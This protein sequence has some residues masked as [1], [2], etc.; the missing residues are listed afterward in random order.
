ELG[1]PAGVSYQVG[2]HLGCCPMNDRDQVERLAARLGAA[3]DG[4]FTVPA[5][6]NVR[7]VPKGVVLQVRNVLTSLVDITGR[8]T[9]A[10]I[11]LMLDRVTDQAEWSK[12]MQIKEVVQAPQ[13]PASPLRAAVDA[14]GYD[15][16]S[17]L[18]EFVS[19]RLNIYDL[20]QVAQPL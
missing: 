13:G 2:D 17:L 4:L 9:D 15:V 20:L 6:M 12:L 14:G 1:L 11:D 3:L 10:M 8:P 19:C 18:T 7:A 16:V 5:T